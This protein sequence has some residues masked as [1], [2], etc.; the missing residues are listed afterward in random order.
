MCPTARASRFPL[1]ISHSTFITYT[2]I[3]FMQTSL[4]LMHHCSSLKARIEKRKLGI[5]WFIYIYFDEDAVTVSIIDHLSQPPTNI[6]Q[7]RK[8]QLQYFIPHCSAKLHKNSFFV[9]TANLRNA[10]PLV[11]S[12]LK[13]LMWQG[14]ADKWYNVY[15]QHHVVELERIWIDNIVLYCGDLVTEV[16]D[17]PTSTK[18]VSIFQHRSN[19]T[20]SLLLEWEK[21]TAHNANIA[22]V[23]SYGI[24]RQLNNKS[25]MD[26]SI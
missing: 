4:S 2:A 9:S 1:C 21:L 5:F 22:V 26:T 19:E 7:S 10:L 23:C 16:G 18:L 6:G 14:K 24:C 3:Y 13:D 17:H 8:H 25:S 20:G 15:L 11:A 12:S